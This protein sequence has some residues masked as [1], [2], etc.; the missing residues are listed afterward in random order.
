M[1]VEKIY[2]LMYFLVA[3]RISVWALRVV[4]LIYFVQESSSSSVDAYIFMKNRKPE[5]RAVGQCPGEVISSKTEHHFFEISKAWEIVLRSCATSCVDNLVLSI[6]QE[7]VFSSRDCDSSACCPTCRIPLL[8][9]PG[10]C[11]SAVLFF[12]LCI[13]RGYYRTRRKEKQFLSLRRSPVR[14]YISVVSLYF[15]WWEIFPFPFSL[16]RDTRANRTR[17]I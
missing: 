11:V 15:R 7:M 13:A 6:F 14:V 3:D 4:L 16:V 5:I 1:D 2:K 10:L 12:L 8:F 9:P 17:V